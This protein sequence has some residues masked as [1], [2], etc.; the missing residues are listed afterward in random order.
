MSCDKVAKNPIRFDIITPDSIITAL[1]KHI[2]VLKIHYIECCYSI[3]RDN[4]FIA[5]LDTEVILVC[6]M[7]SNPHHN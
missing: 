3:E 4:I 2:L 1:F 7:P 6:S 5:V